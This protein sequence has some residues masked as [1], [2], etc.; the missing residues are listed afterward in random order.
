[1]TKKPSIAIYSGEIPS[2]T[3]VERLISGLALKDYTVYLFGIK[4]KSPFYNGK[5]LNRGYINQP[6]FKGLYL[7][8]YWILLTL[9]KNKSKN[10]LD[11]YLKVH[12]R[13]SAYSRVKVYPVLWYQPDIFHV[14][15]AKGLEEWLWVQDFDMKL[16][17]SLRG[18]HINYSPLADPELAANYITNFPKL[19]GFHAVSAAIGKEAELYGAEPEKIKTIYSGLD[20]E[21]L[22]FEP[23]KK[24]QSTLNILSVGRSHWIKGYCYALDA[25]SILKNHSIQFLYT[26]TGASGDIELL[27][28]IK[29]LDLGETVELKKNKSFKEI[30]KLM[31]KADI[32]VLP[33]LKEG[34]ANVVLEAM[35]LGTIVVASDCG[36]MNE[37]IVHGENGFLVPV[38]N[39][40]ALAEMLLH[41]SMLSQEDLNAIKAQARMTIERQHSL[42]TMI[43]GMNALY[44]EV[45][46]S[47]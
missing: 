38:R 15:W 39:P 30:I 2:T 3:F 14:Q 9:F 31:K 32:M 37:V 45:I 5:V 19:E 47:K 7:I 26:I 40:K 35:A 20:L 17:L 42:D 28:Q 29:D 4:T 24:K 22:P 21:A 46:N 25:C 44:M 10:Q 6:I 18:A 8:K 43:A 13:W 34:L 23:S 12:G 27:Y 16:V 11:T 33:S 41:V 1:M 36:G